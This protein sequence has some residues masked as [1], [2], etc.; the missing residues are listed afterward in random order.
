MGTSRKGGLRFQPVPPKVHSV[1]PREVQ[2]C[3]QFW[4]RAGSEFPDF[5]VW[6]LGVWGHSEGVPCGARGTAADQARPMAPAAPRAP[7]AS[8]PAIPVAG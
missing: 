1:A 5:G 7:W 6:P 8:A 3:S 2:G 4:K